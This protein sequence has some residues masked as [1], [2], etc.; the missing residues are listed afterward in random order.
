MRANSLRPN[1]ARRPATTDRA[2]TDDSWV[3]QVA[4][5]VQALLR[6]QGLEMEMIAFYDPIDE[7]LHAVGFDGS[8]ARF[9]RSLETDPAPSDSPASRGNPMSENINP[10]AQSQRTPN[11]EVRA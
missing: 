6:E 10:P 5:E 2:P 9:L 3:D 4:D 7:Q 1:R 8:P 11:N